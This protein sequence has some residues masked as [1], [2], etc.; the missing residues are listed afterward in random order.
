M[1]ILLWPMAFKERLSASWRRDAFYWREYGWIRRGGTTKNL[2]NDYVQEFASAGVP[3]NV[4]AFMGDTP[5]MAMSR[6]TRF[7]HVGDLI[8]LP[9]WPPEY[10]EAELWAQKLMSAGL[11]IERLNQVAKVLCGPTFLD[12]QWE[13]SQRYLLK[14]MLID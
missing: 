8:E 14:Q 12:D 10:T 1:Y 6:A 13:N 4:G 7:N 3:V 11:P 9:G 2:M 5:A